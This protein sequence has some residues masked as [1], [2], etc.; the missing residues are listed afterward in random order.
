MMK[1]HQH[2]MRSHVEAT[3]PAPRQTDHLDSIAELVRHRYVEIGDARDAL[4]VNQTR[5]HEPAKSERCQNG[6][7]V[8]HIESVDIV[9]WIGLGESKPLRAGERNVKTLA[10]LFHC[11]EN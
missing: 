3:V 2:R 10:V 7:L 6:D 11:G 1:R 4:A 9:G 5:I 8:G